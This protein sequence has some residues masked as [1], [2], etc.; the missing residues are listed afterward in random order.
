MKL[1]MVRNADGG[2]EIVC[3]YWKVLCVLTQQKSNSACSCLQCAV[4]F[5]AQ[6]AVLPRRTLLQRHRWPQQRL[7]LAQVVAGGSVLQKVIKR[8]YEREQEPQVR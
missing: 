3:L 8:G 4:V 7:L 5:L 2:G 1:T 6:E